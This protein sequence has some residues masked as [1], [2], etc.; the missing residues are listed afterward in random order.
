MTEKK[1]FTLI[2]LGIVIVVIALL[3]FTSRGTSNQSTSETANTNGQL[4]F[5]EMKWNFGE[6]SM[7]DGIATKEV[8][9]TNTSSS[10]LTVTRMETSCMC[11]KMQIIHENG[12]KS[13]IK[14]MIGHGGTPTVSEVIAPGES[15]TLIVDFDPNAH[16]PNATG[17]ITRSLT[18][19]TDS[20]AQPEIKLSFSGNVI[21]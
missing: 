14:G 5:S 7:R 10:P 20:S 15:A 6:I 4:S 19:Q 2:V 11:T 16:G 8:S 9:M 17:P 21:K 3:A 18:L 13:P 1:S 12:E